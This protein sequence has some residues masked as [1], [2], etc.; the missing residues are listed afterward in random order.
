MKKI[1][2]LIIALIMVTTM[3]SAAEVATRFL[4]V[5]GLISASNVVFNVEQLQSVSNRINLKDSGVNATSGGVVVGRWTFEAMN[6]AAA[7]SYTLT[8]TFPPLTIGG[9][10]DVNP[11]RFEILEYNNGSPTVKASGNTTT[12]SA[13]AGNNV[14]E[15]NIGVRLTADG[16]TDVAAA[17]ASGDY[18][19]TITLV[20]STL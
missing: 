12:I 8:Y 15:R 11:V 14:A 18:Q 2:V 10:A 1:A 19:S 7:V 3:V 6:Q 20:L 5:Y 9:V 16:V 17:P 13:I 4:N